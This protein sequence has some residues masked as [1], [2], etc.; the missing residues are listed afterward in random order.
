MEKPHYFLLKVALRCTIFKQDAN[1]LDPG[2]GHGDRNS[3]W[4]Y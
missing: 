1:S 3:I 4:K 2:F